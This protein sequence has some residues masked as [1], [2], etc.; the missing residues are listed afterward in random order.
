MECL[1]K[2][3]LIIGI[4]ARNF[5]NHI[6]TIYFANPNPPQHYPCALLNSFVVCS[7]SI[8]PRRRQRVT[9]NVQRLHIPNIYFSLIRISTI[10]GALVGEDMI[11][12]FWFGLWL[13]VHV[14][15]TNLLWKINCNIK[16]SA[17]CKFLLHV[18]FVEFCITRALVF[19]YQ[20]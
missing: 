13:V 6:H 14:W 15:A 1:W 10:P 16:W 12:S 17:N 3:V 5:Q 2:P 7:G 19:Y 8:R 20:P 4:S 9:M 11:A 18:F